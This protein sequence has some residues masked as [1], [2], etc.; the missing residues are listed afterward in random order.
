M[1][2]A[3]GVMAGGKLAGRREGC[4]LDGMKHRILL[5]RDL[6]EAAMALLAARGDLDVVEMR[7]PPVA[8][9]HAALPGAHAVLCW[10][11]RMDA[12][13]LALAPHLRVVSRMGVGF[14]TVDVAGCTARG[15]PVMVVN[16]TNDLSVAEHA[17]MLALAVARR[18]VEIDRHV[19]A[20]GWW[21]E[22]ELGMVDLAGRS[23]L[24]VGYGRIGVRVARYLAAFH[25]KVSVFDPFYSPHR[26]AADGFW[27]ARDFRGAL[28]ESDLVTLHCPLTPETRHLMDEAAFA[29]LK[30]GAI[31]VNTARG[32]VVKESALVAALRSGR[33]RGAG[34]DVMEVEPAA[35]GNELLT[36]PNVVVS[37]HISASTD[38]GLE[39][40]AVAAVRNILDALDGRADPAM[41][42]NPIVALP[43]KLLSGAHDARQRTPTSAA[44]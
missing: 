12:A 30:P 16:G 18:A 31:L 32:P 36:L 17:V 5:G 13:A 4:K 37:P 42:V 15:I 35:A 3:R 20:G 14:D 9:W 29:A 7:Y 1:R 39:R 26:I 19:K 33:L 6:P 34:L 27:A 28:A 11:E 22:G 2:G 25:M 24:V 40:M 44:E 8:E 21:P 10:L 43:S 23:A 41:M 38:E